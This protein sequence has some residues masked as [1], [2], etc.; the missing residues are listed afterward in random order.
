MLGQKS[1]RY[2]INFSVALVLLATAIV[3]GVMLAGY[4]AHRRSDAIEQIA[5]SLSDLT[6]QYC[7]PL[8]NELF[9]GQTMAVRETL[10][11]IMQRKNLLSVTT[12]DESGKTMVGTDNGGKADLTED[13]IEAAKSKRHCELQQWNDFSVLTY[14]SPIIAYGETV[15]YWQIHYSLENMN[16]QTLEIVL[17]FCG[18]MLSLSVLIGFLL[19]TIL[20]RFV[21]R[22]VYML[23]NAMRHI[24]GGHGA[25]DTGSERIVGHQ[26]LDKMV[27]AFDDLSDELLPSRESEDEVGSLA[28][29]FQQMLFAL[30]SAYTGIRTDALTGLNNR[31][32]IDEALES[33]I[34]R[35][36]RYEET[37]SIIMLDIDKFKKIND[38]YGHPAGDDV[39][40]EIADL[41]SSA[42]RKTDTPG[43]WGGEEF[44]ILL[45][46]QDRTHAS[47]LAEKLRETIEA[48]KFPHVEKVTA[49][50]GVAE[51]KS[52]DTI[53]NIVE[54]ADAAL[55]RAKERG[56]NRVEAG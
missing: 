21:L 1:L 53:S 55:Y 4:E 49:S 28:F 38:T 12:Y 26:R 13:Q 32:R 47:M 52:K 48:K 40:K 29:A 10:A 36:Q 20:V 11:D 31:M 18:L 54:R 42:F 43:R 34:N 6:T 30:K 19:N 25:T 56:R 15:G 3:F 44:L 51:Y 33:E 23:R 9:A 46:Q 35:A 27:Q 22:P 41:L 14:T 2:K 16:Q 50:F 5:L 45:P 39:L 37:F 7:E 8:G 24:R 17:I